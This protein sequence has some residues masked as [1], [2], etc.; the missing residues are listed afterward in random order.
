MTE[1]PRCGRITAGPFSIGFYNVN[2]A[3]NLPGHYHFAEVTLTYRTTGTLG[4]P[5]FADTH[6]VIAEALQKATEDPFRQHTNEKVA[7]DLFLVVESIRHPI[8]DRWGGDYMLESL[9]LAVRGVHDKIGHADG[10]TRYEVR[11]DT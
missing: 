3:M 7:E 2:K 11:R 6:G 4:F 8:L 9:V 1:R 10:F 5:S